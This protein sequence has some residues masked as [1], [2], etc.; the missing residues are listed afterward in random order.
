[1]TQSDLSTVTR[2]RLVGAAGSLL[3]AAIGAMGFLGWLLDIPVAR[4]P[5]TRP[6]MDPTTGAC[7]VIA[8][9]A[10][11][12]PGGPSSGRWR[13]VAIVAGGLFVIFAGTWVLMERAFA[14]NPGIDRFFLEASRDP[15][16][17]RMSLPTAI[18]MILLG[19]AIVREAQPGGGHRSS[20]W[21]A[22]A[23]GMIALTALAGHAFGAEAMYLFR[24][25]PATIGMSLPTA[26]ALLLLSCAVL[27]QR[28]TTGI[29]RRFTDSSPGGLLVR[30]LAPL[31]VGIPLGIGLLAT[32]ARALGLGNERLA[33]AIL[34]TVAIPAIMGMLLGTAA[35]V[36]RVHAQLQREHARADESR[37]RVENLCR[38]TTEV[39]EAVAAV[40]TAGINPLLQSIANQARLLTSASFGGVTVGSA[41]KGPP[42]ESVLSGMSDEQASHFGPDLQKALEPIASGRVDRCS[43]LA[44]PIRVKPGSA[45]S[46][47]GVPLRFQASPLGTL[48]V[49]D[50]KTAEEFSTDD[51][52]VVEAFASRAAVGLETARLYEREE[53]SRRWFQSIVDQL[54]EGVIAVDET[55]QIVLVNRNASTSVFPDEQAVPDAWGNRFRFELRWPSGSLVDWNE[56]PL[57]RALQKR[58][59]VT[60][61]EFLASNPGGV[62]TPVLANASP[63]LDADGEF[64]GAVV[65]F[66]DISEMKQ[67]ERLREE[68][69][70]IVAHDLRQPLGTVL[71]SSEFLAAGM[72]QDPAATATLR[73]IISATNAL[74]RMVDDLLDCSRLETHRLDLDRRALDLATC[75]PDIIGK[76]AMAA[77]G[78]SVRLNVEEHL[79][80]AFA[81]AGRLEQIMVNLLSNAAKYGEPGFDI[82]VR[83]EQVAP[84]IVLSVTNR[85]ASLTQEQE[86]HLFERFYRTHEARQ[87][88]QGVG[89]G[90]YIVK[91]LVEAHGGHIEVVHLEKQSTTFRFSLPIAPDDADRREPSLL[92]ETESPA[93]FHSR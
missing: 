27:L 83:A 55:G 66:R 93:P 92:D 38:A 8:G 65:V 30:R 14:W 2:L 23:A 85:G 71:L 18:S 16:A 47:L 88:N 69:T 17:M 11:F 9:I 20:E 56:L 24:S 33:F 51:Q 53:H 86:A 19:S 39:S 68:W 64:C 63:L 81:D 25:G 75:L 57:V 21:L 45:G 48:W 70:A 58:E 29:M 52:M 49:A 73:R 60:G 36:D 79:P 76:A 54:P 34:V 78:H 41:L 13:R 4:F 26:I 82:E 61:A 43:G 22:I 74:A 10:S 6:A 59:T 90:L 87:R 72:G 67:L 89:L 37:M 46:F 91:G 7:L 31:A 28:P 15:D 40:P 84:W 12:I 80:H 1:M 5:S 35:A 32:L 62:P 3:A 50:K 44:S 77:A 42:L